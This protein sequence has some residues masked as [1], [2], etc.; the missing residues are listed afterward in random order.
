MVMVI[1][2]VT[3]VMVMVEMVTLVVVTVPAPLTSGNS[4][5]LILAA[6]ICSMMTLL[7]VATWVRKEVRV[8]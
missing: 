2:R 8:G 3:K 4:Y 1:L 6:A 7:K 5:I